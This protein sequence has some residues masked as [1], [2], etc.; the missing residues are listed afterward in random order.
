MSRTITTAGTNAASAAGLSSAD[1][2]ALIAANR[3][4]LGTPVSIASGTSSVTFSNIP[5]TAKKISINFSKLNFSS[6]SGN[7]LFRI[8]S[9]SGIETSGYECLSWKN[10]YGTSQ[11]TTGFNLYQNYSS[12]DVSGIVELRLLNPSTNLWV[13]T[14]IGSDYGTDNYTMYGGGRKALSGGALTQVSILYENGYTLNSGSL[15]ISYS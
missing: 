4:V 14:H 11:G 8:G 2:L 9:N 7:L 10:G 5:T 3:V 6:G 15:N 1:V 13:E 12:P